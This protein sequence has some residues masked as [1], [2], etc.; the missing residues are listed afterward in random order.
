MKIYIASSKKHAGKIQEDIDIRNACKSHGLAS[1]IATLEDISE[2]VASSDVVIFKSIWGYHTNYT[3]FIDQ[4][5]TLNKKGVT[6][7]ND[8]DFICW[9][10]HKHKYLS[11]VRDLGIVPTECI[12]IKKIVKESEM[13][14]LLSRIG[15]KF[16]VNHV[17][18][19]PSVGASGYL[20][21]AYPLKKAGVQ[22]LLLLNQSKHFDFIV[23][24]YR[25]SITE[26][27]LS[28]I[29]ING[30]ILY[31]VVRFPGILHFKKDTEYVHVSS[32]PSL[33]KEK[34]CKLNNFFIKKFG[35][36]PNICRVD[37]LKHGFT[38]EILEIEL[39]DPDL[40]FRHIPKKVK[41]G[42]IS[43]LLSKIIP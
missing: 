19:K 22:A 40:F 2:S 33:V 10:I 14:R 5:I 6:L 15:R 37:F 30:N 38:Y 26:G 12:N 24:P 32:V 8:A 39:I 13:K 34:I 11:E 17:V 18:I 21:K 3:K 35:E 41:T 42:A 43:L 20:T 28:A 31:G 27:E 29:V 16:G 4:I 36:Y 25:T 7:L 9:N 1:K 23:Q